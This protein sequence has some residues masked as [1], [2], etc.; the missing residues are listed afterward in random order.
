MAKYLCRGGVHEWVRAQ[1]R[2]VCRQHGRFGQVRLERD[3]RLLV[4]VS[5]EGLEDTGNLLSRSQGAAVGVDGLHHDHSI[6][7]CAISVLSIVI[8]IFF[9]QLILTFLIVV[10]L[11]LRWHDPKLIHAKREWSLVGILGLDLDLRRLRCNRSAPL[12]RREALNVSFGSHNEEI[13]R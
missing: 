9:I 2:V 10:N 4:E 7:L 11:W 5:R 6:F 8:F 3:A 12:Q 1:G 13:E